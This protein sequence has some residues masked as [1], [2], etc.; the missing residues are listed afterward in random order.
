MFG[1]QD[2][3][4]E[5]SSRLDRTD[6][7]AYGT[8]TDADV[9]SRMTGTAPREASMEEPVVVGAA[10]ERD[11]DTYDR[12]SALDRDGVDT[13]RTT[14]LDGKGV[15]R[16]DDGQTRALDRDGVT[17]R[18]AHD[19]DHVHEDRDDVDR[20]DEHEVHNRDDDRDD[21][22]GERVGRHG[23]AVD[24]PGYERRGLRPAKTSTAAAFGLVFGLSALFC[25]LTGVLAPLAIVLGIIGWIVGASGRRMALRP[26]VT[27]RGL[28]TSGVVLSIIGLVL[29]I[30]AVAAAAIWVQQNGLDGLQT[31]IDNFYTHLPSGQTIVDHLR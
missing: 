30:A 25:A 17:A 22:R 2:R 13:D 15:D 1:S 14:A 19:V 31:Q 26:G 9:T 18:E 28:A 3:R 24:E 21:D 23:V 11:G 27:G 5:G 4:N 10:A 20:V 29:G 16:S 12:T 8:T 7:R 6:D